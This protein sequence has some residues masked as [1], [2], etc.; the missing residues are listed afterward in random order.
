MIDL[1]NALIAGR[2]IGGS[3]GTPPPEP[4]LIE[5]TIT[6]NG[7][8]NASSDNVDG[9]SAVVVNCDSLPVTFAKSIKSLGNSFIETNIVPTIDWTTVIDMS[10]SD[11][12]ASAG[13]AFIFGCTNTDSQNVQN[14]MYG[15]EI[16][17]SNNGTLYCYLGINWQSSNI[18][19][20]FANSGNRTR[21]TLYSQRGRHIFGTSYSSSNPTPTLPTLTAPIGFFG[22]YSSRSGAKPQAQREITIYSAKLYNENGVLVHSLVPAKH[23]TTERGG[24]YDL[25]TGTFYPS[26]SDFDDVVVEV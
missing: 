25:I 10:L 3:G 7:T 16:S 14:G 12:I 8:Y 26:S 21:N 18:P 19:V 11:A 2:M 23:K 5:K 4:V 22:Y 17:T 15:V 24:L 13:D 20:L 9:Y 1:H 6:Q